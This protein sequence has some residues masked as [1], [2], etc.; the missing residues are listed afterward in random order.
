MLNYSKFHKIEHSNISFNFRFMDRVHH[1]EIKNA[2]ESGCYIY[3]YILLFYSFIY[4]FINLLLK[5]KYGS[6][7]LEGGR[8]DERIRSI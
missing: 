5:L 3:G 8:W 7:Y 6:L 4:L 1:S 2:P